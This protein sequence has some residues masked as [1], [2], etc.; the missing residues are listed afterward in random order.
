MRLK[1]RVPA[2]G[3]WVILFG[4][5][6]TLLLKAPG[7]SRVRFQLQLKSTC[8]LT[9]VLVKHGGCCILKSVSNGAVPF[10]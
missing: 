4:K 8:G 6:G 10:I 7:A 3:K 2:T 1:L 5:N 9:P